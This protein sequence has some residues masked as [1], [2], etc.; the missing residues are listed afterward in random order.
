MKP[1][2]KHYENYLNKTGLDLSEEEFIIGG[3]MRSNKAKYGKY[4]R[5]YSPIDFEVGYQEYCR[6]HTKQ[7]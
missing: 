6:K 1:T 7:Y 2:R 4:L 5:K 3:K